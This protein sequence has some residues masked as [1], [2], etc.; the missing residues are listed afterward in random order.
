MLRAVVQ[1]PAML[2]Y[3]DNLHSTGPNSPLGRRRERGLNENLAREILELHTLGVDGGYTQADVTE[4]AKILTGWSVRPL[5]LGDAGGFMFLKALHEPGPKSVL[6]QSYAQGGVAEGEQ[7]LA[8]LAAHPATARHIARKLARHFLADQPP[9]AVVDRLADTFRRTDG[10]LAAVTRALVDTTEVWDEAAP[11]VKT[12]HEF[13]VS[14]MRATAVDLPDRRLLNSLRLFGQAPFD[15]PS[16]AGWPDTAADWASPTA[17]LQRAEWAM[18]LARFA[19][20]DLE[21]VA[22]L[23]ETLGPVADAQMRQTIA[24]A[25]TP[26]E[27]LAMVLASPLFQ[28]R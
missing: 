14:A 11:K 20:R 18:V 12:P 2:A 9:P 16:P 8:A 13:V 15:A 7:A 25:P 21:P 1:H 17:L 26:A 24:Q 10:D 4:F 22:L 27:G 3:L 6:G 19:V 23:D 28:R 5:R